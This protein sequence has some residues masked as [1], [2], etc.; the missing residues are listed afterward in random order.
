MRTVV[1]EVHFPILETTKRI[2][3]VRKDPVV[4]KHEYYMGAKCLKGKCGHLSCSK[5]AIFGLK[6][7]FALA[8]ALI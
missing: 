6:R 8:W 5:I 4:T 3:K 1:S 2:P 7:L